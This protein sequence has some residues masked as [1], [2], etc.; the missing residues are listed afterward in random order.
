VALGQLARHHAQGVRIDDRVARSTALWPRRLAERVAQR[1]FGNK[2]ER[3][4]QLADWLVGLHLLQQCNAKLVLAD[5]ALRDEYSD[6]SG[7]GWLVNSYEHHLS[8]ICLRGQV[9]WRA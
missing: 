1:G 3:N 7:G 4:Q 2:T 8:R 5:H 9:L 6:Q